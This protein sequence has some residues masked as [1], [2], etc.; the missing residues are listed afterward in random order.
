MQHELVKYLKFLNEQFSENQDVASLKADEIIGPDTRKVLEELVSTDR[1]IDSDM[2]QTLLRVDLVSNVLRRLV[3]RILESFVDGVLKREG[4]PLGGVS[5]GAIGFAARASKG[6]FEKV[7]NQIE[8]P[9]RQTM[10]GFVHGS[11]DRL[12][13]QLAEILQS[14]ELQKSFGE[15]R[16]T[17]L[18][19]ALSQPIERWYDIG[20]TADEV[21]Q[22]IDELP[23][24]IG[25]I[26]QH[27]TCRQAVEAQLENTFDAVGD[28]PLH[29]VC[30]PEVRLI[31]DQTIGEPIIERWTAF[32]RSKQFRDCLPPHKN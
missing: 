32:F 6:L 1:E 31:I 18:N 24:L 23:T 20:L 28:E 3:E 5:R 27:P 26:V 19:Y 30:P 13:Q 12:R 9:L 11:M 15:A 17:L 16:L 14:D 10:A 22:L 21:N 25:Q 8:G 2:L 4:A 7:S 29:A